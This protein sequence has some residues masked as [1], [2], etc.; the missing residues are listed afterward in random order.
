MRN[1]ALFSLLFACPAHA[2]TTDG[3]GAARTRT[4]LLGG[5][6]DW[7]PAFPGANSRN[8]GFFPLIAVWNDDERMPVET[9]DESFGINFIGDD[10]DMSAGFVLATSP[11]RRQRDVGLD[12]RNVG[13]GVEAGGFAQSWLGDAVRLRA[14]VRQ[15]IGGHGGMTADV[16][17]DLVY[18]DRAD[19]V[20]LTL[21]LRLRWGNGRHQRRYFG[22]TAEEALANGIAAYRPGS[23]IYA[24][25]AVASAHVVV[26]PTI[27]VYGFGGYERLIG[28]AADSPIV[29]T[30]GNRDQVS[31]GI[32][33]SYRFEV[34]R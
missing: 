11:R 13:F 10:E 25:G 6:I 33:L 8:T 1:L 15:G 27:G 5:V 29:R 19:D 4:V 31:F 21:G 20:H 12:V 32:G 30:V 16:A 14:E 34:S 2:Q 26:A 24:Y 3:E 17:A 9:P 23:G 18:R 28:D 22:V 7:K